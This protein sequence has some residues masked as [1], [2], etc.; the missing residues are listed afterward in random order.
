MLGR[1][2]TS[3]GQVGFVV[4]GGGKREDKPSMTA[5]P[6]A[7]KKELKINPTA[8]EAGDAVRLT[9]KKGNVND[10]IPHT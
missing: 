8:V 2:F 5:V 1:G 6:T 4:H 7:F 3:S 10:K 9:D